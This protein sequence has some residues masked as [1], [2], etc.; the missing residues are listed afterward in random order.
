MGNCFE[1]K[2]TGLTDRK[3]TPMDMQKKKNTILYKLE[4]YIEKK[5]HIDSVE[6]RL[7]KEKRKLQIALV[8]TI[9]V[10]YREES[11]YILK[12]GFKVFPYRLVNE[13]PSVVG[14]IDEALQLPYVIHKGKR[15]YFPHSYSIEKCLSMYESYICEECLLGGK[16]RKKQPHQYLTETFTVEEGDVLV[17]VGCAEALLSL[18]NIEKVSKVYLFE[19][20]P[21]WIPALNATFKDYMHKVVIINKYVSGQDTDTTITLK[22]A[23]RNEHGKQLFIKM[24]I[25]GAEVEVLNGSRDFLSETSN[26]K[27]ACCTYH[28]QHDEEKIPKILSELGYSY[29]FSD[30]Y[31]L[32]Y[33]DTDMRYPYFRHG[34][35]RARK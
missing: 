33:A 15:L 3:S 12:N 13:K 31:M 7:K 11:L 21:M 19:F 4:K 26:I 8:G 2:H 14:G 20:E 23:L 6:N 5:L 1:A 32:F 25:E 9:L 18:D 34:L 30:G 28:K 35:V 16:F 29:E 22:S 27:I 17:D 10:Q 24:D